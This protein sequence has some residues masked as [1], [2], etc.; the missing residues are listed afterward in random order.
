MT[1]A[2]PASAAW[3]QRFADHMMLPPL[4]CAR[5]Y[6]ARAGA[7]QRAPLAPKVLAFYRATPS[8]NDAVPLALS[9]A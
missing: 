7:I 3:Y 4:H 6:L 5:S 9:H 1:P 8:A 2:S